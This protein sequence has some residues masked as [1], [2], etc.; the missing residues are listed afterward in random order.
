M[1]SHLKQPAFAFVALGLTLFAA[2]YGQA[3]ITV[4]VDSTKPWGGFMNV[5]NNSGGAQGGY[6]WGGAWGAADLRASVNTNDPSRVILEPNVNVW[7]TNDT[8]WVDT[9]TIP[10]TGLKWME[11]NFYVDVGAAFAGQDV[12]FTGDTL[13]NTLVSPY[14]A[15]AVIKEFTG[16][17]YGWVGMNTEPLVPGST[18]TVTRTIAPGHFAQYGFILT[19]PDADPATLAS[20]GFAA[21][22]INN[23]DPSITVPPS[24]RRIQVGDSASF[25][26]EAVGSSTLQYQWKRYTTNLANG[27]NIT[28]ATNKTLTVSNAQLDDG[29]T[30]TVTVSDNNGGLDASAT[31]VVKTPAEFVNFLENPGFETG[32][33]SPWW[34]RFPGAATGGLRTTND[35]YN[36]T[37][38]YPVSV[39]AGD[40]VS[41]TQPGGEWS[42]IYQDV[43]AVPGQIFRAEAWF[44]TPAMESIYGDNQTFIEV[45]FRAGGTVLQQYESAVIDTNTAPDV[46]FKLAATNGMP[47][48]FAALSATNAQ[49][50]V[51]PP[52]TTTT[53]RY[54]ISMHSLNGGAGSVYYDNMSLML[55]IPVTLGASTGGGN[56][57]LSWLSQPSTSYDV[58][59]KNNVNDTTW[60][61][62]ET[63][64]GTGGVVTKSY[65]AAG[66]RRFYSVLTK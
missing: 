10:F 25:T 44:L 40:Y 39:Y 54:Q 31:L 2:G 50:L 62:L 63:V 38:G 37:P 53:V 33:D 34:N 13:T 49:Y 58:V 51:A 30:Y 19:G 59:Y 35:N 66:S 55:K 18:F 41:Y 64:A 5:Y 42:G 43:A 32:M 3:Q 65:S 24:N 27:G 1:N 20:L 23:T 4:Q 52:G 28:G 16:S 11:A 15:I 36:Y 22:K 14:N 6:L 26:V 21:I 47:A 61:W 9:N 56:I 45:Q 60:T 48:G 8:Y 12:T 29:T 46:W 17:S 57:N 7:N